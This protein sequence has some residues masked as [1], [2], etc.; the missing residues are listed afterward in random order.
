[1]ALVRVVQRTANF[2]ALRS[3]WALTPL[4][5]SSIN[6][7][8]RP[9]QCSMPGQVIDRVSGCLLQAQ[10]VIQG[11]APRVPIPETK[12]KTA[13]L[14]WPEELR[15]QYKVPHFPQGRNTPLCYA[16]PPTTRSS[17]LTPRSPY[18]PP[19]PEEKRQVMLSVNAENLERERSRR[20]PTPL[21]N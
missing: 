7:L 20:L 12:N 10:V 18:T 1:M 15:S 4:L 16:S 3:C 8:L 11:F 13:L 2:H 19:T 5:K 14:S 6:R 21:S 17:P 9:T